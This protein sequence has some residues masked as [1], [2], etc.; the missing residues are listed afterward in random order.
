MNS[1]LSLDPNL[2]FI[3]TITRISVC[4]SIAELYDI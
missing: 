2:T 4:V 1:D 3:S